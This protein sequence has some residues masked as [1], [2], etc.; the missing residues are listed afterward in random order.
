[1]LQFE[2]DTTP[3]LRDGDVVLGRRPGTG[4]PRSRRAANPH[5]KHL[6]SVERGEESS[7]RTLQHG[8]PEWLVTPDEGVEGPSISGPTIIGFR[9]NGDPIYAVA[10]GAAATVTDWIPNE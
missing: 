1:M 4:L 10:G 6:A 2:Q 8:L 7:V 3:S 5:H 9:K